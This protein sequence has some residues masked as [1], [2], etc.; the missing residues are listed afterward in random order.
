MR[1]AAEREERPTSWACLGKRAATAWQSQP[2]ALGGR[3]E[4]LRGWR[5]GPGSVSQF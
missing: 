4:G 2:N 3:G 1:G 5:S